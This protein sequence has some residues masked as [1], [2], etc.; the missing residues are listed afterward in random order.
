ML[1]IIAG[2]VANWRDCRRMMYAIGWSAVIDAVAGKRFGTMTG[3]RLSLV[4]GSMG[5]ANDLAAQL[6]ILLPFL[7]F[8]TFTTKSLTI[9]ITSFAACLYGLYLATATGSRGAFIAFAGSLAFTFLRSSAKVRLVFLIVI[10]LVIGILLI[11][12]PKE[13]VHRLATTFR[14]QAEA[15]A[16]VDEAAVESKQARIALLKASIGLTLEHPLFGVGPGE[17]A[18]VML[19]K[20]RAEGRHNAFQVAHNAYT[21]LSSEAGIPALVLLVGAMLST[22]LLLRRTELL[23]K[24]SPAH[25]ELRGAAFCIIV[26]L[27]IFSICIFFLSLVYRFY[28]P[29]LSGLAIALSEV[30]RKEIV[31]AQ[32]A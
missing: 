16:D 29:A 20:A 13:V 27:V 31:S 32:P 8:I 10:P 17:F 30:A 3:G 21:Q 22:Y 11:S 4:S 7:L 25:Q 2:S 12:L 5:N 14:D 23:A 18:D 24:T 19:G 6:L 15:V 28:L 1:I 26:A 9:K